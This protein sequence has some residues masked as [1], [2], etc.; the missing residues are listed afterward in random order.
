M[1]RF[2]DTNVLVYAY[3]LDDWRNDIAAELL[4][5]GGVASVQVLNEFANVATR[6]FH[7]TWPSI[8]E[9]LAHVRLKLT[10]ILPISIETHLAALNLAALHG[11]SFYDALIVASA[12]E[13][14]CD[15]LI[16]EDLQAGRR[17]D[18]LTIRNPFR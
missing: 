16:T 8:S 7:W 10:P 14:S 3:T 9:K 13:A 17:F 12:L 18:R 4:S 2:F 1:S 15:E 11:L 5:G 6:K